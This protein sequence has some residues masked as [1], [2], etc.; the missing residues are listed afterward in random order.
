MTLFEQYL[1]SIFIIIMY[2]H[3]P[4]PC[5]P[6]EILWSALCSLLT[7]KLLYQGWYHSLSYSNFT[8][9]GD[10]SRKLIPWALWSL[11][12]LAPLKKK[13]KK[14]QVK[15]LSSLIPCLSCSAI[16]GLPSPTL[17]TEGEGFGR[18]SIRCTIGHIYHTEQLPSWHID[19][20]DNTCGHHFPSRGSAY[21]ESLILFSSNLWA[22][23]KEN[24]VFSI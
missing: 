7:H 14:G 4:S 5:S 13:K 8:Q 11:P 15:V 1:N 6:S 20:H 21:R 3:P 22:L 17:D 18:M 9:V 23:N 10:R 19:L 12:S 2:L 24:K 16:P